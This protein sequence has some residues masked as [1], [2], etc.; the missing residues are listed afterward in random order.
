MTS[1]RYRSGGFSLIEILIATV[2]IA[3]ALFGILSMSL[4]TSTTKENMRELEI[5]KEAASR[6]IEEIRGL[7]WGAVDPSKT[8]IPSVVFTYAK[9]QGLPREVIATAIAP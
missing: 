4:H 7:P 5:A 9:G 2:I 1:Q 3:I 6:K 8:V